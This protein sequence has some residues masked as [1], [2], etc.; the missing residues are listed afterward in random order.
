MVKNNIHVWRYSGTSRREEVVINRLRIQHT[1]LTHSFLIPKRE[2][3]VCQTCG[4]KLTVMRIIT[5][6]RKYEEK[7]IRTTYS[8]VRREYHISEQVCQPL[9]PDHQTC[10]NLILFLKSTNHYGHL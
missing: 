9:G 7:G 5:E 3:P 4:V 6:S 10:I 8:I 2:P 1:Y